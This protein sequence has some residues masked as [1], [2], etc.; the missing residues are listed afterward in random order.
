MKNK[1]KIKVL[2]IVLAAV[3]LTCG[4]P[5]GCTLY[6][7]SV[8]DSFELEDYAE[9]LA[10]PMLNNKEYSYG[11]ID[12]ARQAINAAEKFWSE[13]GYDMEVLSFYHPRKAYYDEKNDAWLVHGTLLGLI[14][15][16]YVIF[17]AADGKVLARRAYK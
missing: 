1:K 9:W 13:S 5:V 16:Y 4:I 14:K 7:E 3:L 10:D 17:S 15:N 2:C 8:P 11:K 6:A 12:S